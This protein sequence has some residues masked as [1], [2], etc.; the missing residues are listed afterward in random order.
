[1]GISDDQ[2]IADAKR[3]L[4]R[5]YEADGVNEMKMAKSVKTERQCAGGGS[6]FSCGQTSSRGP[7]NSFASSSLRQLDKTCGDKKGSLFDSLLDEKENGGSSLQLVEESKL[8]TKILNSQQSWTD[9][10]SS[11]SCNNNN[12]VKSKKYKIVKKSSSA[13]CTSTSVTQQRTQTN[14]GGKCSSDKSI[15]VGGVGGG[16]GGVGGGSGGGGGVGGGANASEPHEDE[17]KL[18][19]KKASNYIKSL[20]SSLAPD[21]YA[22]FSESLNLYKKSRNI[23]VLMLQFEDIFDLSKP[24]HVAF[25]NDFS[26]FV[27]ESDRIVFNQLAQKMCT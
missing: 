12:A 14:S 16:S 5:G 1:M 6:V 2:S 15:G 18:K 7:L 13:S 20:K 3:K 19:M 23:N 26:V 8:S 24:Q 22:K 17:K 10:N 25:V 21:T 9:S 4:D 11:T 27:R